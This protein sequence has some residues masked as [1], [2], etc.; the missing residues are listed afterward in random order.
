MP[1]PNRTLK[2]AFDVVRGSRKTIDQ[3]ISSIKND[4]VVR[5]NQFEVR[6]N[7]PRGVN[8]ENFQPVMSREELILRAQ[9]VFIPG[10]NFSTVEDVNIYGPNRNVVSGITYANNVDVTFLL[11][12]A[13]KVRQ[14]F[15]AWQRLAY[16]ENTWNLNYYSEYTGSIEIYSM[17]NDSTRGATNKMGGPAGRSGG[18]TDVPAFGLKC[19]EAY[20]VTIS[21]VDYDSSANNQLGQITISFGF[22]Y[23]TDISRW[24]TK[25]PFTPPRPAQDTSLS[26]GD[27]DF[28]DE[29][30]D[31]LTSGA[32]KRQF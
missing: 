17:T 1:K 13:L 8:E 22:R 25:D 26:E 9:T 4:G 16:N 11:D 10:T 18:G 27:F 24:G 23:T 30:F 32:P 12:N 21:Q 31:Q 2:N 29:V 28:G 15:D 6:L 19:W 20:P 14:T 7:F 5:T 3:L